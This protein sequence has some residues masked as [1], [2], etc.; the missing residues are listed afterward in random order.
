MITDMELATGVL[1][2]ILGFAIRE[3][4]FYHKRSSKTGGKQDEIFN[5]N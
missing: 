3:L 5:I 2:F 4:M 1:G